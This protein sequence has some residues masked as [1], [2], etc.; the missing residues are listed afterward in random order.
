VPQL[1]PVIADY[2]PWSPG[3]GLQPAQYAQPRLHDHSNFIHAY[4]LI[5]LCAKHRKWLV[6]TSTCEVYGRTVSSYIP[7]EGYS[8][9]NLYEQREDETPLVMGPT[10][11]HR[12]SYAAAKALFERFLLAHG[13]E[14]GLPYTIIRPYNWFGPKMDFIPGRDGEGIP[15]V[16]ACF[17][18]ALLDRQPMQLVDGGQAYRTI[19]YIDDA[20][21]ALELMLE[22]PSKSK[23]Q[24]FNVG[25]FEA[26]GVESTDLAELMHQDLRRDHRRRLVR[27]HPIEQISGE[28]LRRGLRGLRPARPSVEGPAPARLEEPRPACPR[29]SRITMQHYHDAY[30][31]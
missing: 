8:D 5:Q 16:L 19:T 6:H 12:W 2:A 13:Q 26:G 17:M 27:E 18:T 7:G 29:R 3:R 1:E 20:V 22:N 28:V 23:N 14:S 25:N 30:G 15:R 31:R 10:I 9:P 21:D 24:I 4:K 11:N